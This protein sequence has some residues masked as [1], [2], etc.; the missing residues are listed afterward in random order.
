MKN[1]LF[2]LSM[3]LPL[4]LPSGIVRAQATPQVT[5]GERI[6]LQPGNARIRAIYKTDKFGCELVQD[7]ADF[8]YAFV[9]LDGDG[10]DEIVLQAA[11]RSCTPG[12]C[13][14]RVLQQKGN[15][16]YGLAWQTLGQ[17][18]ALSREKVNGYR[19]LLQLDE[20]GRIAVGGPTSDFKGQ[21]L[22]FTMEPSRPW[23]KNWCER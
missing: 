8:A 12:G 10:K 19:A 9:D 15:L 4:L 16:N 14:T 23:Q 11:G 1:I 7:K 6:K 21:P 5:V 3:A 20:Q 18:L 13:S 2:A 17:P 22:I